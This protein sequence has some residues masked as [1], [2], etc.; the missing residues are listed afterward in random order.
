MKTATRFVTFCLFC[1]VAVLCPWSE[2]KAGEQ[3]DGV[4]AE[5]IQTLRDLQQD[6]DVEC[7]RLMRLLLGIGDEEAFDAG[8]IAYKLGVE[9]A[10]SIDCDGLARLLLGLDAGEKVDNRQLLRLLL[11]IRDDSKI[12]DEQIVKLLEQQD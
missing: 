11:G 10:D 12:D 5:I 7:E 8:Q 6:K 1:F 4:K 2:A 3:P 9:N